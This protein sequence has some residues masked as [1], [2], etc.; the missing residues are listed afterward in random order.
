MKRLVNK[1]GDSIEGVCSFIYRGYEISSSNKPGYWDIVIFDNSGQVARDGCV[2]VGDAIEW[3]NEQTSDT[4]VLEQLEK[5]VSIIG[6]I[7]DQFSAEPP[8]ACKKDFVQMVE[9]IKKARGEET[10]TS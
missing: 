10:V 1:E 3:V 7:L 8:E 9:T 4:D 6:A 5:A 2:T